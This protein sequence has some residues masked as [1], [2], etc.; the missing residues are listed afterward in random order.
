MAIFEDAKWIWG[1]TGSTPNRWF[2]FCRDFPAMHREHAIIR[3]GAENKY[4]LYINGIETVVYGGLNRGPTPEN[5]Y[6]DELEIGDF[7]QDGN[8]RIELIV[9]YWGNGGRNNWPCEAG[10]LFE[11]EIGDRKI[12]SD[13]NCLVSAL[14]AFLPD[15]P[16]LPSHLYGGHNLIYDAQK[17]NDLCFSNSIEKSCYP[18]SPWNTLEKRSI[19]LFRIGEPTSLSFK[20]EEDGEYMRY[21]L[22]LPYAMHCF[23]RLHIQASADIP[24]IHICTDRYLVNGGPGDPGQYRAHRA[25]YRAKPGE[26]STELRIVLYGEALIFRIPKGTKIFELGYREIGYDCDLAG[27]FSCSDPQ[28]NQLYQKC[29]RTLYV[30]MMD[31]FMDC[32]DRERGQ[33]IGDVSTQVP[34]VFYA[35]SRSADRL[36]E[37][38]MSDFIRCRNG[39][40][41]C[42]NVPGP[43]RSEL[44]SQSLNAI[45]EH[46]IFLTYYE[47]TGNSAFIA[48]S[49][50]AIRD[51]LLLWEV[52]A[53]GTVMPRTGDWQWYDHGYNQ[54]KPLLETCFYFLALKGFQ[55]MLSILSQ[56]SDI[57]IQTRFLLIKENFD[58]N[59]WKKDGYRSGD[60]LDDRAN[61]LAVLTG[62]PQK[63]SFSILRNVLIDIRNSTPYMEGYV[64]EALAKIG[65]IPAMLKRMKERYCSLIS[66]ENTTLWEDFYTLGTKNHAWSGAP[67]TLLIKYIAGIFPTKPGWNDYKIQPTLCDLSFVNATVPTLIGTVEMTA[68]QHECMCSVISNNIVV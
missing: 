53:D 2:L 50:S 14:P 61:A 60:F 9:W 38:A 4:W 67:L 30:C 24:P 32:P 54:D 40:I 52:A 47:N 43:H 27:S 36:V 29:A 20:T 44:P 21:T 46:G 57:G 15:C 5:G 1:E 34:Q 51:Y 55:K 48:Q 11:L 26:N 33:W 6:Y 68:N 19:P 66:N 10:L 23:P 35:L 41:L 12:I 37:K 62:I 58:R 64:L 65:E 18:A 3:I 56:P 49:I 63:D 59:Y 25:E 7:L 22:H 45:S 13:Q 28:L 16:P 17:E 39:K 8:N 31:N 42:G